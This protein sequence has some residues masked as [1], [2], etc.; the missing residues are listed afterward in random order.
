MDKKTLYIILSVLI[1]LVVA[2]NT[3]TEKVIVPDVIKPVPVKPIPVKPVVVKPELETNFI[4]DDL[5]KAINLGK[6]YKRKVIVIFGADW[7]P[8]C[9]VLKT[10]AKGIKQFDNFIVCFIDTDNKKQNQSA[11]NKYRPRS[12]PTS[13]AIAEDQEISRKIG[14]QKQ[15]YAKWLGSL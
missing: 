5:S 14:Y 13:V 12:L 15:N 1:F 8:Y 9:V 10:E 6:Q 7:C 2:R 11:I 4:Y 3:K